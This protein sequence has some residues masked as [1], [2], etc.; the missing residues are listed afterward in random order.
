MSRFVASG[1]DRTKALMGSERSG[2]TFIC[3][4]K[5]C[6]TPVQRYKVQ[7]FCHNNY[8]NIAIVITYVVVLVMQLHSQICQALI[9]HRN[10]RQ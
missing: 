10:L 5:P 8:V 4:I 9:S 1:F 6:S 2:L 7:N 3:G